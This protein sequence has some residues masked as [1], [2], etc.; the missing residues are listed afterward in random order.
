LLN[1]TKFLGFIK[2]AD[3]SANISDANIIVSGGRGVGKAEGFKLLKELADLLGGAVGASRA[4]VDAEWIPYCHQIGQ[5][6][7]TVVPKLYIACGISGQIQ[8]TIGM[9]SSDIIVAINKDPSCNMMQIATYALEGDMYEII[10]N[11]IKEIKLAKCN[12]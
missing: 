3:A 1:R 8:H 9:N 4:A 12:D 7:K 10:P 11:I 2:D 5:T 6:G